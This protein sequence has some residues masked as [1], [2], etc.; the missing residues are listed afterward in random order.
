MNTKDAVCMAWNCVSWYVV[1]CE[2]ES[3]RFGTLC[4]DESHG[5][6]QVEDFL[7]IHINVEVGQAVK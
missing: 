1:I 6:E 7:L 3:V 4:C 5:R 2:L